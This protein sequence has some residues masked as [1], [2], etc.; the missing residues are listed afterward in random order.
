MRPE[1]RIATRD[2]LERLRSDGS[3]MTAPLEMEFFVAVPSKQAGDRVAE[4]ILGLGFECSLE[5]DFDG[6]EWTC[7]CLKKIVPVLETVLRIEEE[8]DAIGRRH[9]GYG[10]GF[11]S[12]GN[13]PG[14]SH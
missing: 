12:F 3:D 14:G 11:G 8:L 4:E 7:I 6:G 13:A 2:A 9:G 1:E 10:D 5:Q